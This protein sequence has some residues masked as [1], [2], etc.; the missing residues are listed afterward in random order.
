MV[1]DEQYSEGTCSRPNT[2]ANEDIT[3]NHID[4]KKSPSRGMIFLSQSDFEHQKMSMDPDLLR[5]HNMKHVDVKK[6]LMLGKK[7]NVPLKGP[8]KKRNISQGSVTPSMI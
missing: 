5:K 6:N 3:Y 4:K 7:R 8:A 1:G 2:F